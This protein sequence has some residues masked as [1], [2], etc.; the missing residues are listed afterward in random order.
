MQLEAGRIYKDGRDYDRTVIGR[1]KDYPGWAYTLQGDWYEIAT[2]KQVR[3]GKTNGE[4]KYYIPDEST[5]DDL[6]T[7]TGRTVDIFCKKCGMRIN[8]FTDCPVCHCKDVDVFTH[9]G[10]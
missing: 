3:Y 4:Y 7:D 10:D 5:P 6:V 8:G 2:G 9:Q 1:T